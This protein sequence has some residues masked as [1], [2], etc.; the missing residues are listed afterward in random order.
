[1]KTIGSSR[2]VIYL[3]NRQP[4]LDYE[5]GTETPEVIGNIIFEDVEFAYPTRKNAKVLQGIN[6]SIEPGKTVALVG[7]SG[8]GKS[9]LVS[10]IEQ[11]YAPKAGKVLLD[12]TP[13]QNIDH[14]Y[15][16]SKIALVA[17][18][19]TLFSG[20]IRENILY[21]IENGTDEDMMKV[22][23]MAN[24][25]EFVS[26]MEKGYDTK[27][28]EKGVQ[29][30]GGQKQRIAIARALIR[31]PRILILDEATSALDAESESMVQEA[32]NRCSRDRTVLVIAHRLSTVKN[33]DRI[34]VI[35]KGIVTETGT[36]DTL[37]LNENGLYYKLVSKQLQPVEKKKEEEEKADFF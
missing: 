29:M 8:N 3:L 10:L 21:G 12:G 2:K 32:L 5:H 20:T 18:E 19:P 13:V 1:M 27:C 9:T 36:H 28:G 11:F 30:S 26:K 6:L 35:E 24:V 7:P 25:H 17:Q 37:M 16:H 22:S 15:Y 23:E 14:Q 34:A 4:L 33:A 31:D